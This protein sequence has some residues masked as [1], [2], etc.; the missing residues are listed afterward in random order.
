[1]VCQPRQ[2]RHPAILQCSQFP[3][4]HP[5]RG[6]CYINV[7]ETPDDSRACLGVSRGGLRRRRTPGPLD[8]CD[9]RP[10]RRGI[11]ADA[12]HLPTDGID[13]IWT[14][15][16]EVVVIETDTSGSEP[17][18]TIA[19]LTSDNDGFFEHQL[20]PG[21]YTI[22]RSDR[23]ARAHFTI[24]DGTLVGCRVLLSPGEDQ[25]WSCTGGN[26]SYSGDW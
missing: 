15:S 2:S 13:D 25:T 8:T 1:M 11:A 6:C 20:E 18:E 10:R 16:D 5:W 7:H 19:T 26:A 24:E 3:R 9:D 12:S 17:V 21:D 22:R 23:T 14:V 4:F